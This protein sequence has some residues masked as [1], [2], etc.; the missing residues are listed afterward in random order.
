MAYESKTQYC[1][2]N[3]YWYLPEISINGLVLHSVGCPQP[4][5]SVFVNNFNKQSARA[6]VH[7]F[8]EPGLFIKTAPCDEK[9]RKAKKCYHVGS[10]KKGSFNSTRIGIEMT[11]PSTITYTGG[12]NFRD[13]NPTAT[14]DFI[15][16]T[17]ATAAEVFADLCIFH[18]LPVTA[19]TTHR[20]ACLDGYGSNHGDPEHL[21]NHVGYSLAQFR[22]DV[23]A[24]INAK[25]DYLA[26][27]TK[28]EFEAVLDERI[29]K[30]YK[31]IA[32]LPDYAKQPVRNAVAAGCLGG[33]GEGGSGDNLI[34]RLS[35]D[36]MRTMVI[37][38]RAGLFE[39]KEDEAPK[40]STRRVI[41]KEE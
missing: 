1:I 31:T 15:M 21:W 18:G 5:A 4:K 2:N 30:N 13:N 17:T 29:G 3:K 41:K 26:T 14:K 11:E 27:M 20:Q 10:G 24:L 12:A 22:N 34:I 16:R 25:G 33:T 23:Q 9:K 36:L 40:T 7:G 6:S 28:A 39:K 35:H 38:D 32:D 8:I 19:I 37:L